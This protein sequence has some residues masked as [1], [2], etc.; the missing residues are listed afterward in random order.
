MGSDYGA[1][2]VYKLERVD[3]RAIEGAIIEAC[4]T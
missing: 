4:D 1:I 2:D 3:L